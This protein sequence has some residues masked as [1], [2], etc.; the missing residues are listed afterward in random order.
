MC[1]KAV[2]KSKCTSRGAIYKF[3]ICC[4]PTHSAQ[5][6][7]LAESWNFCVRLFVCVCVCVCFC[8]SIPTLKPG[9]LGTSW[10][11][12]TCM[13]LLDLKVP[14]GPLGTSRTFI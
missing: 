7:G 1:L 13:H 9:H 12:W 8:L 14:L 10:I 3:F 5:P 6:L 2:K 11:H 4:Y